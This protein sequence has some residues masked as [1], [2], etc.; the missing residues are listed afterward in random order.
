MPGPSAVSPVVPGRIGR[1]PDCIVRNMSWNAPK[2][3]Q[4]RTCRRRSA[5][6]AVL[7]VAAAGLAACSSS[8]G[9]PGSGDATASGAAIGPSAAAT[10]S[11]KVNVLYAGSLVT[12]MEKQ[13]SPG[14][15][16][17]T[18]YSFTGYSAGS[19]DLASQIKGQVHQGDVFVSA[20]PTA[21]QQLLGTSNGNWLSWYGTFATAPLVLGYNPGQRVCLGPEVEALVRRGHRAGLPAG[22]HRP[23]DR[24]EG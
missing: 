5:A 10:G 24:P 13:I 11:G 2:R 1:A 6:T 12:L 21:D 3:R 19:T 8:T 15:D 4:I 16:T 9:A 18:G 23:E 22:Q 14:F 17:Q 7:L 20:S